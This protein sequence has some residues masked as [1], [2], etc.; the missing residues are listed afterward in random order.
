LKGKKIWV[1]PNT[2]WLTKF[3]AVSTDVPGFDM[4]MALKLGTIDGFIW[5]MAELES[6][7]LK[8][9]VKYIMWPQ[10]MTPANTV[11]VNLN[12]W[13]SLG[14]D[15]QRQIQDHVDAHMIDIAR[16]MYTNNAKGIRVAEEYGVKSITLPPS[17]IARMQKAA[18]D[19]WDE[20]AAGGPYAA[21]MI[22]SYRAWL[23][24]KELAW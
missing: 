12:E 23:K 8:E 16:E 20:V 14:P 3:G 21:K 24:Y 17:D 15:L 22:E 6:S 13:D 2:A 5:T 19:F 7:N 4:Y 10:L 11:L 18:T 9:V 1:N